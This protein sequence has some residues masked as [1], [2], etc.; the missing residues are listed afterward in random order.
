MDFD[1][2]II[3]TNNIR[4]DL[5][6]KHKQEIILSKYQDI[7]EESNYKKEIDIFFEYIKGYINTSEYKHRLKEVVELSSRDS[8]QIA[9]FLNLNQIFGNYIEKWAESHIKSDLGDE[10]F[11]S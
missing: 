4:Y 7:T 11:L 5:I 6:A 9:D 8:Q 3:P 1:Q 2:H 10:R